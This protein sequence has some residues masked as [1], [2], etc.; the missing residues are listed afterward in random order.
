[1]NRQA[2]KRLVTALRPVAATHPNAEAFW[3][4][5]YSQGDFAHPSHPPPGKAR[6]SQSAI[7]LAMASLFFS[8]IIM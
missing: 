7:T 3:L 5:H 1:M 2:A 8:S 6:S 4:K